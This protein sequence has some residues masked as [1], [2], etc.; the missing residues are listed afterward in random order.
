MEKKTN[1]SENRFTRFIKT[2]RKWVTAL[3]ILA[4]I[5]AGATFWVLRYNGEAATYKK[6]ILECTAMPGM[7]SHIHNDDC[8]Q[9]GMLQNQQSEIISTVNA[10]TRK[11]NTNTSPAPYNSSTSTGDR[12]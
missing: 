8:Y 3:V 10:A 11:T 5:I 12:P 4:V 2:R 1:G 6:R 7:V 9:D